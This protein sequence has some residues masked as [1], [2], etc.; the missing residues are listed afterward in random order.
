MSRPTVP[1]GL[2]DRG[3]RL[4]WDVTRERALSA[5]ALVLLEEACRLSDRLDGLHALLAG[6]ARDWLDWQSKRGA[7]DVAQI[8]VD[9]ALVE[10]R[11]HAAVLRQLLTTL[12]VLAAVD[13]EPEADPLDELTP[14][15]EAR[16]ATAAG[17]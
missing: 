1:L 17:Q 11:Q 14:R 3:K 6:D 16:G 15:R 12:D 2:R 7:E 9:T 10:A 13:E 5:A 4:W 8:V